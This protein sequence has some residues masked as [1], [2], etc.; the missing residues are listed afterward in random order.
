MAIPQTKMRE[1]VFQMLYSINMGHATS[2]DLVSLMMR[3][4]SVSKSAATEAM[5][6]AQAIQ[7][8][9]AT[10]DDTVAQASKAYEFERI[11]NIEKN[12]LRLALFEMQIE[13]TIPPKVVIAEAIRLARKFGTP[14]SASFV[15]A[16]LDGIYK[17]MLKSS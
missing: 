9:Q 17:E 2:S 10:I 4:L 12:I 3:E 14:E 15:N 11:H 5:E 6:R 1:V 16:L 8:H 7:G 13:K